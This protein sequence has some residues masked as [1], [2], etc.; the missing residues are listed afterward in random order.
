MES[1]CKAGLCQGLTEGLV[2]EVMESLCKAGLCQGLTE[3]LVSEVMESLC[4]A[5][6]CQGLTEG[7]VSE[8]MESLCKTGLCQGLTEGLDGIR[9]RKRHARAIKEGDQSKIQF[10]SCFLVL[11]YPG[12]GFYLILVSVERVICYS[13]GSW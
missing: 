10:G 12:S 11:P 9:G 7:L 8:V 5:G 2:S 3:G 4:K 6:L 13:Y 1:L